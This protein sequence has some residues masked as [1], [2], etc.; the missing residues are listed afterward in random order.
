MTP[1][2]G[3]AAVED[4]LVLDPGPSP[5]GW[6]RLQLAAEC[7]QKY[8]WSYETERREGPKIRPAL[9][10]GSL[11]HLLLAQH[12]AR[13]KQ[14]QEGRNPEEYLEPLEAVQLVAEVKKTSRFVERVIPV[15]EAYRRSYDSD[16]RTR[17]IREV[18]NIYDGTVGP[19]RLTGRIDLI[20]E[21][22]AGRLHATDHKSTGRLTARHRDYYTMS[23]QFQAYMHL[24]R[25][26]HG[27][28]ASFEINLIQHTNPELLRIK[29]PRSPILE[30]QFVSRVIDIER[31]IEGVKAEGRHIE[32][33]PK[34]MSELTCFH[35]YGPCDH[36][37]KCRFG[38]NAACAG[39]F[40]VDIPFGG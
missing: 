9:A 32:E 17:I 10:T 26:K 12:Y 15:Y 38:Q 40:T 21:D 4:P 29:L 23:G 16:I 19:Y 7:L 39:T 11:I 25:Q 5:R 34:A 33:W 28:L 30:Q 27:H 13:M 37:N 8:A 6:H 31:S 24:V 14:E 1:S 2:H 18:E 3:F 35:R 22:L 20:W 36:M